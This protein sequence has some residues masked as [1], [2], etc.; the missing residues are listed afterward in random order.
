MQENLMPL[1]ESFKALSLTE[2]MDEAWLNFIK[3]F[4]DCRRPKPG[5]FEAHGC[6]R[7]MMIMV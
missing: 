7:V 4:T 6:A 3:D 5:E 1:L 2:E